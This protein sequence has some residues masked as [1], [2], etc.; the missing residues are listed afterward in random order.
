[1]PFVRHL[2]G[3]VFALSGCAEQSGNDW[4]TT[5]PDAANDAES[6]APRE[7]PIQSEA[8]D[9]DAPAASS[10]TTTGGGTNLYNVF[11][12][13]LG[14]EGPY[15]T[16]NGMLALA[17]RQPTLT[18]RTRDGSDD[19]TVTIEISYSNYSPTQGEMWALVPTTSLGSTTSYGVVPVRADV[20]TSDARVAF[21]VERA[22]L[23]AAEPARA[24][25]EIVYGGALSGTLGYEAFAKLDPPCSEVRLLLDFRTNDV[26]ARLQVENEFNDICRRWET[27]E[28]PLPWSYLL[29]SPAP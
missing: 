29:S 24:A 12:G 18:L 27:A 19:L 14:G 13:V 28:P 6:T 11:G 8:A 5:A 9:A 23:V 26:R 22:E 20:T 17:Q 21:S 2:L 10:S 4:P 25:L 7:A 1:M 3:I 15:G 16:G